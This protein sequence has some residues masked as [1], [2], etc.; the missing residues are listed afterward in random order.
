[1]TYIGNIFL[2]DQPKHGFL[3]SRKTK[4]SAI[5]PCLDWALEMSRS[6]DVVIS[7]FHSEMEK[8]VLDIL[9]KGN[10]PIILVLARTMYKVMPPELQQLLDAGRLLIISVSTQQRI[11]RESALLANRYVCNNAHT[12]TFGFLSPDSSLF[13]LYEEQQMSGKAIKMLDTIM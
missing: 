13:P 1:M 6:T 11:S 12:L 8:A 3:C 7:T 2:L 5:L 9:T 4:S 10:C